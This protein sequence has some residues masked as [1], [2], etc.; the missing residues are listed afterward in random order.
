VILIALSIS[1]AVHSFLQNEDG[2]DLPHQAL[3]CEN[4]NDAVD[5]IPS[6]DRMSV[7]LKD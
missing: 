3:P 6:A 7:L 1:R 2:S 5:D 4:I